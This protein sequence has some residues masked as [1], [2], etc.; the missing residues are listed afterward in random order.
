MHGKSLHVDAD[1]AEEMIV[2][3]LKA[4]ASGPRWRILQAL[5]EGSRTV[6]E[7]SQALDMPLSTAAAQ[8]K[9]LEDAGFVRTELQP[10]S[11]GLQ[12]VCFR[13]YDSLM[14]Q[15]PYLASETSNSM[16]ISMPVGAYTRFEVTPTCGLASPTA[17]IGYLDDPISFYEPGR[18]EAGLLWFRSGYVE[19]TF[20]NRLQKSSTLTSIVASM[21]LCSEA[22]L[23]N[24][25]WPS[26]ITLWL[27]GV[28][29]GTWT[30]PGDFG[31]Q[32]GRL[33]PEWWDS[34]DSQYGVLKRWMVNSEGSFI[35]GYPLSRVS[36]QD[37]RI[38]DSPVITLRMGVK[39]NAHHAGGLNL[40]GATFGNYPQDIT[41]RIEQV[42]AAHTGNNKAVIAPVENGQERR[43]ED[44]GSS[45]YS[46]L[47]AGTAGIDSPAV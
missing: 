27:N 7:V 33:T 39:H 47:E 19:Y 31:G 20:P 23:H 1:S 16:E 18:V 45:E 14:L 26:D 4:L 32:R 10:A 12:K 30:C 29:I 3:L 35:D 5:S 21:E 13:T 24:D 25:N 8:I 37:L 34:K 42:R 17:L 28:E 36:V 6:M 22:P 43:Y 41:L 9:T 15:L 40:F 2:L 44:P 46:T 38:E 11:H